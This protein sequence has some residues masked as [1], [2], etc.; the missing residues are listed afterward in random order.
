MNFH[1]LKAMYLGFPV[2]RHMIDALKDYAAVTET[3]GTGQIID[4]IN[5]ILKEVAAFSAELA[6]MLEPVILDPMQFTCNRCGRCCESFTI[7]VAR[8]DIDRI[9]AGQQFKMLPFLTLAENRPTFQFWNKKMFKANDL[10]YPPE[11]IS[12]IKAINPSLDTS[13]PKDLSSCVFYN[14]ITKSCTVYEYRP[15]ECRL[16]PIGNKLMGMTNLLCDPPCFEQ[17]MPVDMAPIQQVYDE[18][19]P[20][21]AAFVVLYQLNPQGGWRLSAFKLALLFDRLAFSLL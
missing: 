4:R 5:S 11:L 21:D 14:S 12:W 9:I 18:N 15:A 6:R 8:E 13:G 20:S 19:R 17:G 3:E 7:G 16:Y 10:V 2:S 1:E